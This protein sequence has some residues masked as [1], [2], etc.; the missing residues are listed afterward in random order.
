MATKRIVVVSGMAGA[1]K[2][3]AARALEDLG[4]FVIDNLPPQLIET[5]LN[6]ADTAGGELRRIA[7]V[8]DAREA[9][10]LSDF[11]PTWDR[12]QQGEHDISL[13][14]LDCT[15]EVLV[16]RFKETRRRHPL[17]E[18]E[19]VV[20]GIARERALLKELSDRADEVIPTQKMSVHELKRHITDRFQTAEGKGRQVLTVMSFGFKYGLP[21]ELDLCFDVRFLPNP[22]FVEEL[23]P[24]T[25]LDEPV[26]RFVLEQEDARPF[27][28]RVDDLVTFLLPRFS[29]EGKAYVTVAIGCTGGRHRSVALVSALGERLKAR[30]QECRVVH[31]DATKPLS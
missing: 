21:P 27:L 3:T 7:L 5:L 9:S 23:R 15:D 1:G 31:R 13:V 28:D 29:H 20:S 11:A 26:S 12:L 25:G 22:Y 19:G 2:T 4:F 17:D 10:F 30:G 24:L 8:I 14:F 16:S 6:L 18:G